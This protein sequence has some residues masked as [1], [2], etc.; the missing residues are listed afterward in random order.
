[1]ERFLALQTMGTETARQDA[2]TLK[3]T[4]LVAADAGR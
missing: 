2:R 1:V 3:Q 4:V